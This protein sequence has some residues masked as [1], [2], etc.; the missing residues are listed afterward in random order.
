[1]RPTRARAASRTPA[2]IS[3]PRTPAD[4]VRAATDFV[5]RL[6]RLGLAGLV[7]LRHYVDLRLSTRR[8]PHVRDRARLQQA[9]RSR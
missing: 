9:R 3:R 2:T 4:A 7:A 5:D 8:T 1:M 6:D